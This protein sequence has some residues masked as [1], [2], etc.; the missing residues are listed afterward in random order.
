MV[1]SEVLESGEKGELLTFLVFAPIVCD[2]DYVE[3]IMVRVSN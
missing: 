3:S 2:I 1:S